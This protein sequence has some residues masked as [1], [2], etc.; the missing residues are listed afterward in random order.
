[1]VSEYVNL[2]AYTVTGSE[3]SLMWQRKR[4]GASKVPWGLKS[5]GSDSDKDPSGSAMSSLNN[6]VRGPKYAQKCIFNAKLTPFT[7][8]LKP[9][10]H[11]FTIHKEVQ[12]CMTE[13]ILI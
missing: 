8:L 12:S 7:Q 11:M 4:R 9:Y 5:K 6:R 10:G 3:K 2:G 13:C 1:M